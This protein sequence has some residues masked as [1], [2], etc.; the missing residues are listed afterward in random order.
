M[1]RLSGP[2]EREETGPAF[3]FRVFWCSFE[4]P[5]VTSFVKWIYPVL[6]R[7]LLDN[8]PLGFCSHL[9]K[10]EGSVQDMSQLPEGT[11]VEVFSGGCWCEVIKAAN[12]E[13][14]TSEGIKVAWLEAGGAGAVPDSF[15]KYASIRGF[16]PCFTWVTIVYFWLIYNI[17]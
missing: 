10:L 3:D 7:G 17:I 14:D 2:R 12:E 5:T 8:L 15:G 16:N 6:K 4:A 9:E 1:R 11:S 13:S